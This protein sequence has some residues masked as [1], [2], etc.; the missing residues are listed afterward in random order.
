MRGFVESGEDS[1]RRSLHLLEPTLRP[2]DPQT[3][4]R[5][6]VGSMAHF[7]LYLELQWMMRLEQKGTTL[8]VYKSEANDFFS[9]IDS[10]RN[11]QCPARL[12]RN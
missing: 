11:L 6:Y 1:V 12:W 7:K 10:P 4:R 2:Q 9:V 5:G 3:G 8:A